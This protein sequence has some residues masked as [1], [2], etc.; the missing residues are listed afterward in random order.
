MLIVGTQRSTDVVW[1]APGVPPGRIFDARPVTATLPA[2]SSASALAW[3]RYPPP[4]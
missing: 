4:I 2:A 3:V 1:Y